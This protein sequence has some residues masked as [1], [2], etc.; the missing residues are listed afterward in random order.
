MTI[1]IWISIGCFLLLPY[2]VCIFLIGKKSLKQ[3]ISFWMIFHMLF[4]GIGYL[5][6]NEWANVATLIL[7]C[8]VLYYFFTYIFYVRDIENKI[9]RDTIIKIVNNRR[10][11]IV[12]RC[13]LIILMILAIFD[14]VLIFLNHMLLYEKIYLSATVVLSC[15]QCIFYL[16]RTRKRHCIKSIVI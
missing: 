5:A 4:A 12:S 3:H 14:L 1:I 9:N 13:I 16:K 7:I 11:V 2:Y 8:Y 6:S 10:F 15:L